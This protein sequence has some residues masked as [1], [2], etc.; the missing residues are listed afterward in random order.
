VLTPFTRTYPIE[1]GPRVR[2]RLALRSDAAAV[3]GLLARRGVDASDLELGRL[4]AFDPMRR[5][6][7]C[8]FA[9]ID[10]AETLVG[11]GAID[12]DEDAEPD[13]LVVDERLAGGLSSLLGEALLSRAHAH[14]RRVA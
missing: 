12:L 3:R 8:A 14:G 2:L 1:N 4:L 7:L 10:A 6:V 5:V 11:I 9:P 13:T